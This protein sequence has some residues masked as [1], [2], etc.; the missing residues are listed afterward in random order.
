MK[1]KFA[2]KFTKPIS[3]KR[4]GVFQYL[5]KGIGSEKVDIRP[6]AP[7]DS[8]SHINRKLSAKYQSLYTNIFQQ[9]KS[10]VLEIFLD[11]NY[12]RRGNDAPATQ[13]V[14]AYIED[15]ISY[16]QH[17]HISFRF[18]YPV[19]SRYRR[20]Y[21]TSSPIQ[22]D[23]IAAKTLL[24]TILTTITKTR[25][26]YH[27]FLSEFLATTTLWTQKKVF[28][29]FSDFLLLDNH[30]KQQ[31]HYLHRTHQFFLFQLPIDPMSGQNYHR[32]FLNKKMLHH[33]GWSTDIEL[34]SID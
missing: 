30:I 5:M 2:L 3:G 25:P 26:Y 9:E 11:I 27:S 6:Y 21:L 13:Q 18:F 17:Q 8:A 1:K 34:I 15:I 14:R 23:S 20:P 32:Y 31:L 22:K 29:L 12:N 19:Y 33:L 4:F 24:T 16:C 10:F 28:V 7:G